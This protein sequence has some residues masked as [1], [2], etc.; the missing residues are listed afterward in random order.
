[1]S[2]EDSLLSV[3]K[4]G[5]LCEV[6]RLLEQDRYLVSCT[7]TNLHWACWE[8]H[9]EMVRMLIL[10]F[11]ADRNARNLYNSTPVHVAALNGKEE[12]VLTLIKEFGCDPTVK[13]QYGRSLLHKACDSGNVSLVN[14]SLVTLMRDFKADITAR[15]DDKDMPIHVAALAGKEEVVLTLIKEFGCDPTVKGQLVGL[16]FTKLL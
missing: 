9:L 6:R 11:G 10:E 1:M 13:G 5:D 14:V 3:V 8:G 4:S 16:C 15:D 2:K 12:V 7:D